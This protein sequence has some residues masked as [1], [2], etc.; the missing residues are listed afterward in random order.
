MAV[1]L[2]LVSPPSPQVNFWLV[3][4]TLLQHSHPALPHYGDSTWDWLKGACSTVDR[5]YGWLLNT[6]H[7]HIADT[8]VCHHVFSGLPHYHA[9]EATDALRKVM[10]PYA[11]VDRRNVASALWEDW[12]DCVYVAPDTADSDVHWYRRSYPTKAK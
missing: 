1:S 7:H 11:L 9:V 10:G 4:I 12:R 5:S 3:T 2:T 6:L 8:H